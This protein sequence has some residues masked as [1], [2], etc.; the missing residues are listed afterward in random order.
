MSRRALNRVRPQLQMIF[1]DPY[2]SLNPRMTVF[3]TLAEPLRVHG[4]VARRDLAGQVARLMEQVGLAARF[5]RKYPHEFSGGQR[6]RI[7]IARALA[8]EPRLLIADE[9]VS[10]LDVSV[11][12][13]ILNL[14]ADLIRMHGLA[15]ILVS[16]DLAVV[17]HLAHRVAVM[18]MG[19][20]VEMGATASLFDGP[21]HA[22]TR[23]LLEATPSMD[24]AK[25]RA[26]LLKGPAQEPSSP[27][28]FLDAHAR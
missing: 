8:L 23:M 12:A 25:A 1:Q 9:P 4:R 28:L 13:Q 7:A 2:S 26:N 15:L 21:R 10:A 17:R 16:H 19:R 11:Q 20:I 24:P 5:A 3:D 22:Y 14:L 6:Q 18:Y 27:G